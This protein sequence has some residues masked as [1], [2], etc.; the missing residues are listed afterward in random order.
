MNINEHAWHGAFNRL[1]V[2][3]DFFNLEQI[4]SHKNKSV[5]C[6][7]FTINLSYIIIILY[8]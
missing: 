2:N 8:I 5:I 7:S 4:S 3:I 1:T 6:V